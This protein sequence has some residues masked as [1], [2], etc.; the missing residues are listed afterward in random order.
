[1]PFALERCLAWRNAVAEAALAEAENGCTDADLRGAVVECEGSSA[2]LAM[3]LAEVRN[4]HF[5]GEHKLWDRPLAS[6]E[7]KGM[8]DA[9]FA[10]LIL[11][12]NLEG[13]ERWFKRAAPVHEYEA[14]GCQLLPDGRIVLLADGQDAT[15]FVDRSVQRIRSLT[16]L[17][18]KAWRECYE[19]LEERTPGLVDRIRARAQPPGSVWP[20]GVPLEGLYR[21]TWHGCM[22]LG[23]HT[24]GSYLVRFRESGEASCVVERE[25]VGERLRLAGGAAGVVPMGKADVEDGEE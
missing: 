19:R 9:D 22:A 18:A 6:S 17:A 25:V 13:Y 20:L 8:N 3:P 21:E 7:I 12:G 15:S 23:I 10:E 4:V 24:N 14:F 16:A 11:R 5:S 2:R 1:M